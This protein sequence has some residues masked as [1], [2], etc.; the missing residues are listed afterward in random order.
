MSSERRHQLEHN[1]LAVWLAKVNKSIEPYSKLIGIL[2]TVGVVGLLAYSFLASEGLAK[3]SDA[4]LQ[5]IQAAGGGDTE[6]LMLVSDTY[7]DTAAG[8]WARLYQGQQLLAQGMREL[9]SDRDAAEILLADAKQALL[10]AVSSS[11]ETLLVS[12]GHYG[13]AQACEG[14]GEIDGDKGA[15][16]SYKQVVLV[17]ES[18]AMVKRAEERIQALEKQETKDFLAW[19]SEQDFSIPDPAAP[20]PLPSGNS[21]PSMPLELGGLNLGAGGESATPEGGIE[22]PT[23]ETEES[24]EGD[25]TPEETPPQSD[26]GD[27]STEDP[28]EASASEPVEEPAEENPPTTE[29]AP[30]TGEASE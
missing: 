30:T 22:L 14:L 29:N 2:M 16:A 1:E 11:T 17:N 4:T 5:L 19:F 23:A 7:P 25:E 12:R 3:R 21:I 26:N 10:A 27:V 20:P 6:V 28:A 8:D 18:E 15:I 24:T 9:Y 13:I